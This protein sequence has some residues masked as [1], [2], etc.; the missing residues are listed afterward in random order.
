MTCLADVR[1]EVCITEER[2]PA[3]VMA[4]GLEPFRVKADDNSV[5]DR[6]GNERGV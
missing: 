2:D 1:S 5:S 4:G 6:R 3:T